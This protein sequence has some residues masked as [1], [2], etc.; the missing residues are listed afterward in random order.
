LLSLDHYLIKKIVIYGNTSVKSDDETV[1][2]AYEVYLYLIVDNS[3]RN[4][5]MIL[6]KSCESADS[7]EDRSL[8]S[9][10]DENCTRSHHFILETSVRD[11]NLRN[12]PSKSSKKQRFSIY[13]PSKDN[14][15]EKGIES[16]T[17]YLNPGIV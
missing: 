4:V 14:I 6:E 1:F 2:T 3:V 13:L 12:R 10:R 17:H 15:I 9:S 11:S 8:L 16:A 7:L 5:P